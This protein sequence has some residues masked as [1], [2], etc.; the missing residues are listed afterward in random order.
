MSWLKRR[1][2]Y[3]RP[4]I[5]QP[6]LV[7]YYV[8]IFS[9]ISLSIFSPNTETNRIDYSK[10]F[11]NLI[12]VEEHRGSLARLEPKTLTLKSHPVAYVAIR[13][14]KHH[15]S[16][17]LKLFE[18]IYIYYCRW[19][20]LKDVILNWAPIFLWEIWVLEVLITVKTSYNYNNN[21]HYSYI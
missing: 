2:L 15:S 10:N 13:S 20:H 4:G 6:I 3:V 12:R 18:L 16:A 9:V 1:H 21:F 19:Y 11:A 7:T 8:D 14:G 17:Y 5:Y